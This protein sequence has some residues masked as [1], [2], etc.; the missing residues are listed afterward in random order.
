MLSSDCNGTLML[1]SE[2][3]IVKNDAFL[4][5]L[6]KK[7][8]SLSDKYSLGNVLF[9][10]RN[11]KNNNSSNAFIIEVPDEWTNQMIF[12]VWDPISDEVHDFAKTEGI[13]NLS[14][15]CTVIVS[16]RY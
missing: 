8:M 12:D 5:K 15:I 6:E 2:S 11:P 4:S 9:M 16:N 1:S 3:E 14:E 7:V 13:K 10:E